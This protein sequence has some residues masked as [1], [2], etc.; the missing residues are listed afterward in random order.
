MVAAVR[1]G[2]GL[3][4]VARRFGTS[5]HT[6]QR[7]VKRAKGRS[8]DAV[9]WSDG[10]HCPRQPRHTTA[11]VEERVAMLRQEL[12][13]HSDL[14]EYGAAAIER[15]LRALDGS[16]PSAR[17]IGRI[18]ERRGLLDGHRRVRRPPPPR[19]WYLPT[20]GAGH[21]ELDSFDIVEG[22][23]IRGGFQVEVLNAI[24][25]HGG[26]AQSWPSGGVTAKTAP[27]ALLA[28]WRVVGLPHY[29][30]FDNDTIFQGPHQCA[31]VISR[32][33]RTCLSL[34]VVPVFAP[35][36]EPGFQAA[37]ESFNGRWQAKVWARFEHE[38]L[39]ALQARSARYITALRQRSVLRIEA[40][41]PRRPFPFTWHPDLQAHP[42]GRLIYLRRTTEP[43][44]VSLLGHT[45]VVDPGWSHRLVRCEID[46]DASR[47]RFYAL[48]RRQPAHQ[49]LLTE[50][51]YVLPRRQFKA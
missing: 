46:L 14:G 12:K 32:V 8:V 34:D 45:F 27:D 44:A 31:D 5:L 21:A 36:R 18:L 25:L 7:W 50:I 47:I 2:A 17:T 39:G 35:P 15:A 4:A 42:H 40:A 48:R 43:G 33:M 10:S 38:S 28:H 13:M 37:I 26:L 19:G 20:V 1:R 23:V 49:P 6:V 16:S 22:L 29:A 3:R 41:P 24:S 30:Q 51:P 11:A 9:D